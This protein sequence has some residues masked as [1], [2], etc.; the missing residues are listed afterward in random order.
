MG[1]QDS[2]SEG[3]RQSRLEGKSGKMAVREWFLRVFDV[4]SAVF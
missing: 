1:G 4:I 3:A 2:Q